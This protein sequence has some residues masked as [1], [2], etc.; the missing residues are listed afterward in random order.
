[1]LELERRNP[2]SMDLSSMTE[3]Q[4]QKYAPGHID[5]GMLDLEKV[6][7]GKL[8]VGGRSEGQVRCCHAKQDTS[9]KPTR[10]R[11][12]R[13]KTLRS[14]ICLT[15]ASKGNKSVRLTFAPYQG[16]SLGSF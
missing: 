13:Q 15:S 14:P 5:V 8:H 6:Y 10:V 2:G 9:Q 16:V 12:R 3:R 1:M 11:S 7:P 4:A